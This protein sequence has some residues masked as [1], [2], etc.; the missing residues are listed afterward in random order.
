MGTSL[1]SMIDTQ[2]LDPTTIH[3]PR[4]DADRFSNA[5]EQVGLSS[6]EGHVACFGDFNNDKFTDLIVVTQDKLHV[7][8]Y[9]WDE[10]AWEFYYN[11]ISTFAETSKI[12]NIAATD[13][14]YDGWLDLLVTVDDPLSEKVLLHVYIHDTEGTEHMFFENYTDLGAADDQV[15]LFDWDSDLQVDLLG[16]YNGKTVVWR[17][18]G[19]GNFEMWTNTS[20]PRLSS[21]HSASFVDFDGNCHPDLFLTTQETTYSPINFEMWIWEESNNT[22]NKQRTYAAPV[23]SGQVIF[24]DFDRNA[25]IDMLFPVCYPAPSCSEKAEIWIAYNTQIEVC[26]SLTGGSGCLSASEMC[27]ADPNFMFDLSNSSSSSLVV[28]PFNSIF[29]KHPDYPITI[30]AGDYN[31]DGFADLLISATDSFGN[32]RIQLWDSTPC[33][34][35]LGCTQEQVDAQCRTFVQRTDEP[36]KALTS[37]INGAHAAAFFDLGDTGSLDIVVLSDPQVLG[38]SGPAKVHMLFNGFHPD[39]LFFKTLILNGVC[40]TWCKT[41]QKFP[42]IKPYGVNLPG[43]VTKFGLTDISGD[44]LGVAGVQLYQSSYLPLHTPYSFFGLGRVSNFISSVF[45]GIPLSTGYSKPWLAIVPNS[46]V[47]C[48]PYPVHNT[49]RWKLL[50]FMSPSGLLFWIII[51]LVTCLI[52]LGGII[53][54]F[55]IKETKQDEQEEKPPV[56]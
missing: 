31:V 1:G 43:G 56:H 55:R 45:C 6:I 5:T 11:N 7:Q 12:V 24:M 44:G 32:V 46:Q 42:Q 28:V 16:T 21:P 39:A 26:K 8:I 17:N 3:Q 2:W 14:N 52:G 30:R 35:E 49:D 37:D 54:F 4:F 23:G 47:V 18:N 22:Y 51:A 50:L 40:D 34:I 41:G 33:S 48:I 9:E 27:K 53:L 25:A 38:Q 15:L 19:T 29:S 13:F 20:L 36:I 10:Y